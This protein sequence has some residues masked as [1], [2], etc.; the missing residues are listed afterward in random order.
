MRG[1]VSLSLLPPGMVDYSR[2]DDIGLSDSSDEDSSNQVSELSGYRRSAQRGELWGILNMAVCHWMGDCGAEESAI[3]ACKWWEKAAERGDKES[4][5]RLA[6]FL[7]GARTDHNRSQLERVDVPRA[8]H[9]WEKAAAQGDTDAMYHIANRF[10]EGEQGACWSGPDGGMGEQPLPGIHGVPEDIPKAVQWF[11]KAASMG[12][13]KSQYSLACCYLL[14]K[15]PYD[16]DEGLKW[17][18]LAAEQ[19]NYSA[20]S[21]LSDFQPMTP[22]KASQIR[23]NSTCSNDGFV[24]DMMA[25]MTR[26]AMACAACGQDMQAD[27]GALIPCD[28][29]KRVG[30]CSKAC[31]LAHGFAHEVECVAA[32]AQSIKNARFRAMARGQLKNALADG[33]L[34][35]YLNVCAVLELL[36]NEDPPQLDL[37]LLGAKQL[38]MP[39]FKKHW[40][41]NSVV[42]ELEAVVAVPGWSVTQLAEL[43]ALLRGARE[44]VRPLREAVKLETEHRLCKSC[45]QK[46]LMPAFTQAQ[47]RKGQ[48]RCKD[49]QAGN[50]ASVQQQIREAES[51]EEAADYERLAREQVAVE[52]ANIQAELERRNSVE[53]NDDEC[54]VCFEHAAEADRRTLSCKHWLCRDC[55]TDLVSADQ[56]RLRES[57]CPMCRTVITDDVLL[58]L[59]G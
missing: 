48:R 7:F 10:L 12:H 47:W 27:G 35:N 23:S 4:Q 21:F 26:A 14:G 19:G 51:V 25:N 11:Q 46:K 16:E 22:E 43:R 18:N 15:V 58:R 30:W 32:S 8:V 49:C 37:M 40:E 13:A 44:A 5:S 33:V 24:S 17:L 52:R 34:T 56:T 28:R 29:C 9:W 2:F 55:M 50:V 3:E 39:V 42:L 57:S 41:G 36:R 6:S 1:R 53:H 45:D 20:V 31:Q 38:S 54:P 59:C